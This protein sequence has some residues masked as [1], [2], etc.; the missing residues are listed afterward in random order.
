MLVYQRVKHPQ[1]DQGCA[2]PRLTPGGGEQALGGFL[3]LLRSQMLRSRSVEG[4]IETRKV[5][6]DRLMDG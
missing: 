5:Y 1:F 3:H 2:I 4:K 6:L